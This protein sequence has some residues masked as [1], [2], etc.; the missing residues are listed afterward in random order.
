MQSISINVTVH[1]GYSTEKGNQ[2]DGNYK[3][4]GKKFSFTFTLWE[5]ICILMI[6]WEHMY[7]L[8]KQV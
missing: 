5:L 3:S 7:K 1:L 2:I 6:A 4:D 8:S